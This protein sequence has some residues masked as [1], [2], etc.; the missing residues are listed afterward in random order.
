M[1]KPQSHR[2]TWAIAALLVVA[3]A[4]AWGQQPRPT[5]IAYQGQFIVGVRNIGI[6]SGGGANLQVLPLIPGTSSQDKITPSLSSDGQRVAFAAKVGDNFQIWTWDLGADNR[7][8]GAA[9]QLTSG[10]V[11]REQPVFSPDGKRIAFVASA[12]DIHTLNVMNADGTGD[13]P[14]ANLGK[15][16][17]DATPSWSAD[18]ARLLFTR[19]G[20]L[21]TVSAAGADEKKLRDDAR[22]GAWSPDGRRVAYITGQRPQG[23]AVM[24]ADGTGAREVVKQ[25][26][27]AGQPA[28]SPDGSR[29]LFRATRI[30]GGEVWDHHWSVKADGTDIRRFRSIGRAHSYVAWA[31]GPPPTVVAAGRPGVPALPGATAA[32]SREPV[33]IVTPAPDSVV[34]GVTRIKAATNTDQAYVLIRVDGEFVAAAASPYEI[35]WNT[36][37]AREGQH[38]IQVEAF[39]DDDVLGVVTRKV[40]VENTV[41]DPLPAEGIRLELRFAQD[42]QTDRSIRADLSTSA[43]PEPLAGDIS[44][45]GGSL[46]AQI[47]EA[48]DEVATD[49][50]WATVRQKV[51]TGHTQR[52]SGDQTDLDRTSAR[53]TMRP[54]WQMTPLRRGKTTP[55]VPL[56]QISIVLPGQP[57]DFADAGDHGPAHPAGECG[58][59]ESRDPAPDLERGLPDGADRVAVHAPV[60]QG[61][62]RR[63]RSPRSGAGFGR[64][65][66]AAAGRQRGGHARV[67]A[68][69]G[70]GGPPAP[71][72]RGAGDHHQRHRHSH[73]LVRL[74]SAQGDRDSGSHHRDGGGSGAAGSRG[75]RPVRSGGQGRRP[76]AHGHRPLHPDVEQHAP[77][78]GGIDGRQGHEERVRS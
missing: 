25:L 18:G 32:G 5:R 49:Q 46:V 30:A 71:G 1:S 31:P 9:R 28:W 70:R 26:E 29:L 52:A 64:G 68:R 50:T 10:D 73:H 37:N 21:W 65:P 35:Q 59:R 16:F 77:A 56:A 15:T 51:R 6:I 72:R 62:P 34:R 8:L 38:T 13:K 75:R 2:W 67:C 54:N 42:E 20:A 58:I 3:I 40:T 69:H 66:G 22:F 61:S 44:S 19:D 27:G 45:L 74:R 24:N 12:G 17:S 57:V 78:A 41:S 36:S 4:P 39:R 53:V 7:P 23:L 60:A 48:V 63:G 14:V 33:V 11:Y 47:L 55:E 43:P 76:S